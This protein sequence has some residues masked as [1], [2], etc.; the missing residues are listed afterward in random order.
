MRGTRPYLNYDAIK[1]LWRG[2][3]RTKAAAPAARPDGGLTLGPTPRDIV[4]TH[5]PKTAGTSIRNMLI[6][7]LPD[8][9]KSLDYGADTAK[10]KGEFINAYASD[11]SMPDG[12]LA[13]RRKFEPAQRLLMIG[14]MPAERYLGV[15][16][17]ASFIA[18]VRDPVDRIV[19]AYKYHSRFLNFRGTFSEFYQMP[20][21]HNVQSRTLT[22]LDPQTARFIG[23]T[24]QMPEMLEALSRHLGVELK[25]RKD[26]VSRRSGEPA[27]DERTRAHILVL[28]EHDLHLYR[29]VEA[30][31]DALTNYRDRAAGVAV[32][33]AGAVRRDGD[34]VFRGWAAAADR[35]RLAEIEV[36]MGTLVVHRCYADEFLFSQ[37]DK[38]LFPHGVGGFSVRLPVELLTGHT[39][40]RFVFA[41][42]ERDLDGSPLAP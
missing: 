7:A 29:H 42:S 35:G 28:N 12:I 9:V 21:H 8:T 18:F 34:G 27:V 11:A 26:N 5:I 19:S 33:G 24:E 1:R 37:S 2:D 23:V 13:L 17:P 4:F 40:I 41:G 15:F 10:I 16:H 39:H 30:N 36:R 6:E 38:E 32:V 20:R 22:D 31:L 14:H 25:D 3:S